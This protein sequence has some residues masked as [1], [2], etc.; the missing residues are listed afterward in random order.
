MLLLSE[1]MI[2]LLPELIRN[3]RNVALDL[4]N[5]NDCRAY[6]LDK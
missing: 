2:I 3:Y 6:V 1:T 5:R 4:L